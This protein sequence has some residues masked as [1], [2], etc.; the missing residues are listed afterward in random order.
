[1][2]ALPSIVLKKSFLTDERIFLGPLVRCSCG[3]VRDHIVSHKNDHRPPYRSY[4]ALQRRRPLKIDIREIF[5]VARF[6]TFATVSPQQRTFTKGAVTSG[7]CHQRTRRPLLCVRTRGAAE[8]TP[9]NPLSAAERSPSIERFACPREL[10][11]QIRRR[12]RYMFR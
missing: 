4:R 8:L 6:S 2:S 1:M 5:G 12:H 9:L 11:L 10:L 7:L 3:D